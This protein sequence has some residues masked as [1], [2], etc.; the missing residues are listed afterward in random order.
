MVA[1]AKGLAL[2]HNYVNPQ[3]SSVS[4]PSQS[5][6]SV[7]GCNVVMLVNTSIP[8]PGLYKKNTKKSKDIEVVVE[9]K[10]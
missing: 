4:H 1:S 9:M 2:T 6:C 8:L 7:L 3:F 5:S 10:I